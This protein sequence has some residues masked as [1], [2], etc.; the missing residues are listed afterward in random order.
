MMGSRV[1]SHVHK[2]PQR[3]GLLFWR[4]HPQTNKCGKLLRSTATDWYSGG[5]AWVTLSLCIRKSAWLLYRWRDRKHAPATDLFGNPL[6]TEILYMYYCRASVMTYLTTHCRTADFYV[7]IGYHQ[8]HTRS[9][10]H[11]QFSLTANSKL[12]Q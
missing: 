9:N 1:E 6:N 7:I 10:I 12:S 8:T 3:C 2:R 11:L 4:Y 5:S